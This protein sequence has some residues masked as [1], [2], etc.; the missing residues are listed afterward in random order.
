VCS[1]AKTEDTQR[2]PKKLSDIKVNP[3]IAASLGQLPAPA[4]AAAPSNGTISA[5]HVQHTLA[6]DLLLELD[7][8]AAAAPA[9]CEFLPT[10]ATCHRQKEICLMRHLLPHA[11][12][13]AASSNTCGSSRGI[14]QMELGMSDEAM[15]VLSRCNSGGRQFLERL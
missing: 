1:Q 2:A 13:A 6:A 3:T 11:R 14:V 4:S 10:I 5:R 8:P 12:E 15:A 7:T 9:Q